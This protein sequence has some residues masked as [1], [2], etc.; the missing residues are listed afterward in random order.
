[1][2]TQQKPIPDDLR[3]ERK[4]F[5]TGRSAKEIEQQLHFHPACFKEIYNERWINN[6]YLDTLGFNNY[7]DNL[8]GERE[9]WKTRIRWYGGLFGEISKPV[10]EFKIKRGLLGNKKSY[11]LRSFT[12]NTAF[13][14]QTIKA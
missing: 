3:Y 4:F 12:L 7:Y 11:P 14:F 10:L 6:I 1:M 5:I 8:E 9:R 2:S 13:N